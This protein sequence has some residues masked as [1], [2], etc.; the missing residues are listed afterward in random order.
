MYRT[1]LCFSSKDVYFNGNVY[2]GKPRNELSWRCSYVL[3][4]SSV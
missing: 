3:E 2:T 4:F 1:E